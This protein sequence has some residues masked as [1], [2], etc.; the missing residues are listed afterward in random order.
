[1]LDSELIAEA[2]HRVERLDVV[3][4]LRT[5]AGRAEEVVR[6]LADEI[7]AA[8]A[9]HLVYLLKR[10]QLKAFLA[11]LAPGVPLFVVM[12]Q[13][14]SV[15]TQLWEM[16]APKYHQRSL[17]AHDVIASLK[18][19]NYIVERTEFS[20]HLINPLTLRD[21]IRDAVLSLLCYTDFRGLDNRT[22]RWVKDVLT[23]HSA[24]ERVVCDCTCYEIVR[25]V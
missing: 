24:L 4:D 19:D 23:E 8:L 1:D 22:Q 15:F 14:S 6:D 16:T 17:A 20:T 7:D 3:K 9:V 10:V 13:P 5:V 12:D 21:D 25:L 11:G 2:R 18:N